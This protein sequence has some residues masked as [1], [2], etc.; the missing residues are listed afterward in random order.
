MTGNYF[1]DARRVATER[2]RRAFRSTLRVNGWED[3]LVQFA[4]RD[5]G[6]VE[7][8]R[9]IGEATFASVPTML[10]HGESD[11]MLPVAH[12]VQLANDLDVVKFQ[13]LRAC[14][15]AP[16]IE[17]PLSFIARC[18]P[19]SHSRST[20]VHSRIASSVAEFLADLDL[21]PPSLAIARKAATS[22]ATGAATTASQTMTSAPAITVTTA[23]LVPEL[24]ASA[25]TF[26]V[27]SLE[28]R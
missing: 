9:L 11:A 23:S 22:S 27:A 6:D 13:T 18:A 5:T 1:F 19:R 4:R 26:S 20:F 8:Q 28:R 7:L 2:V 10:L 24:S 17:R 21:L 14:G 25:A 15:H 16:H 3:A 12:V